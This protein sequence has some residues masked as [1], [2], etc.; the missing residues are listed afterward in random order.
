M[1][2]SGVGKASVRRRVAL[3]VIDVAVFICLALVAVF[4]GNGS[5][6]SVVV[7]VLSACG[8]A[9]AAYFAGRI[10]RC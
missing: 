10:E 5:S 8:A 9:A 7:V 6:L 2:T 1:T 4:A 3:R